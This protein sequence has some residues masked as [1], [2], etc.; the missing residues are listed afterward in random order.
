MIS[1]HLLVAVVVAAEDHKFPDHYGFDFAA[2]QSALEN[3]K[4][5][6]TVRGSSTITQQVAKNIFLWPKQKPV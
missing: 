4:N 3:N 2:I 1:P 6:R 5:N